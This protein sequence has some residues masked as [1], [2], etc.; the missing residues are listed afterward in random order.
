MIFINIYEGEFGQKSEN[1]SSQGFSEVEL[2]EFKLILIEENVK[3]T[4]KLERIHRKKSKA[5]QKKKKK[6]KKKKKALQDNKWICTTLDEI[7]SSPPPHVIISLAALCW[8]MV[9]KY[10]FLGMVLKSTF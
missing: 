8:M 1:P 5:K 2:W 4:N 6:K 10:C 3:Y 7:H 9:T